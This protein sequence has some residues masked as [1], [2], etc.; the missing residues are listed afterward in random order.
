MGQSFWDVLGGSVF[1]GSGFDDS[2]LGGAYLG[3]IALGYGD[4]GPLAQRF[5][6]TVRVVFRVYAWCDRP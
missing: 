4:I 3:Q 5:E 6:T 1:G 2:V